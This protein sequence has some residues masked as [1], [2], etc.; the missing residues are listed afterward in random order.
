MNIYIV[1]SF[2]VCSLCSSEM[3]VYC[4]LQPMLAHIVFSWQMNEWNESLNDTA[5]N[6]SITRRLK[7]YLLSISSGTTICL[8]LLLLEDYLLFLL[9]CQCILSL[10]LPL[11]LLFLGFLFV[12]LVP[13]SRCCM[14]IFRKM[15]TFYSEMDLQ[16]FR[17]ETNRGQIRVNHAFA[18]WYDQNYLIFGNKLSK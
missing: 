17:I 8:L 10:P 1:W 15:W 14:E 6:T 7:K 9:F 3:C 13:I 16:L 5:H 4:T 11:L 2:C 18:S 12:C